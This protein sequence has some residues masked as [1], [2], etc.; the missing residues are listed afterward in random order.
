M[1]RK[2]DDLVIEDKVSYGR[3]IFVVYGFGVY[4]RYSVLAGQV[5]KTWL[6]SYDTLAEAQA[7]YPKARVGYRSAG[8]T[9]NHL[10]DENDPVAGGMYPDDHVEYAP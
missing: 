5:S 6:E 9:F 2:Y 1:P 10:P 8:N 4:P 7:A 3:R